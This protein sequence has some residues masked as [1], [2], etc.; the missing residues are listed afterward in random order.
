MEKL[1]NKIF[2]SSPRSQYLNQKS[3]IVDSIMSVLESGNYILGSEVNSFE[4][5]FAEYIGS[6]FCIGVNSGTDAIIL[7]LKA[8]NIKSGDEVITPSHTAVATVAAICSVGATPVFVDVDPNYFT[9]EANSLKLLRLSKVRA[10][11]A[12]HL[13]GQ[14]CNMDII[15]AFAKENS[16]FLIE[17]CSQAHGAKWRSRNVGTFGVISCFS[18]YPTKNLGAIGD[19]GAIVTDHAD[20]AQRIF[21]LRQYG[22]NS[23]KTSIEISNVSRLD[24]IQ[25]AILRIKLKGLDES[26]YK[27]RVIAEKYLTGIKNPKIILPKVHDDAYHVFHLFVIKTLVRTKVIRKLNNSHIFPGIHYPIPVHK[28]P[29]FDKIK[30][31]EEVSLHNTETISEEILSLPMYPELSAIEIRRIISVLNDC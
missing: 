22:W 7:A 12:V 2:C 14:P 5:E 9:I 10:I 1:I 3:K 16:I 25:A 24:E 6:S 19:G 13:Y 26:N 15:S 30:L 23:E 8:L 29:G 17:D 27:R 28:H 20:L 21:G 11:I 18:F 31:V 4:S